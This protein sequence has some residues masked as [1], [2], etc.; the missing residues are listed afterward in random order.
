MQQ[1]LFLF[2]KKILAI[3]FLEEKFFVTSDLNVRIALDLLPTTQMKL[4]MTFIPLR[5]YKPGF[6]YEGR[7]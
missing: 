1:V 3:A 5:L 2:L 6:Y 7:S 4:K